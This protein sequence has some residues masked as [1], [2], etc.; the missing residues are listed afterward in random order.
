[1]SEEDLEQALLSAI[2]CAVLAA[3]GPQ[4]SRVLATLYK[5]ERCARLPLYPFLE[6]VYLER[7]LEP[8]EVGCSACSLFPPGETGGAGMLATACCWASLCSTDSPCAE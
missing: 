5:D 6:K 1:V 2:T 7:I 3:A 4:R 8:A